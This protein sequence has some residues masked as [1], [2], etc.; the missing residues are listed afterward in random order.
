MSNETGHKGTPVSEAARS[1]ARTILA[2]PQAVDAMA[3]TLQFHPDGEDAWQYTDRRVRDH[4]R[5][6]TTVSLTAVSRTPQ[7]Q[8]PRTTRDRRASD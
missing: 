6:R 4:W 5:G 7:A 1:A 3:R 8:H 2:D